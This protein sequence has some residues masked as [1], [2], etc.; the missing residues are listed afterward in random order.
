L[1]IHLKAKAAAVRLLA[2]RD[3][4]QDRFLRR[5]CHGYGLGVL[6][7]RRRHLMI[8]LGRCDVKMPLQATNEVAQRAQRFRRMLPG[9]QLA[10]SQVAPMRSY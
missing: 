7:R 3:S 1:P 8:S 5:G 9:L 6:S 2:L 10:T 4:L